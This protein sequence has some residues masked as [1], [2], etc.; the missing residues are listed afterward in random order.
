MISGS[1]RILFW[2]FSCLPLA[3]PLSAAGEAES[4]RETMA[5]IILEKDAE[6]QATQVRQ[7]PAS[8]PV[9]EMFKLWREGDLHIY[10]P[11][12]GPRRIVMV[13]A[14]PADREKRLLTDFASNTAV[15]DAGGTGVSV[16]EEDLAEAETDS[17]LR[18]AME[19]V[20]TLLKLSHS[21]PMVR[22]ESAREMGRSQEMEKLGLLRS[23]LEVENSGVV[24]KALREAIAITLLKSEVD[25]EV[26]AG[27]KTLGELESIPS[28]DALKEV[29]RDA[30][31]QEVAAAAAAALGAVQRH[32]NEVNAWGTLFRGISLGS[33]LLV[34]ALGLAI[35]F[36]LMGVIN[37]AHGEMIAIGAYTTYVVQSIFGSGLALSAFGL[38]VTLPGLSAT[39]GWFD[40]YFLLALPLSFLAAATVGMLLELGIIRF[41]YRRPLESLL[42]TWGVSLVLQQLFRLIIGAN[43]VSVVSP[44]WLSGNWT[45]NDVDL[46]WK[47]LFVVGFAILIVT[48][49][50]LL[51]RKTPLG[52]LIRAVMQNRGMAACMGVRT[53]RVNLL[54]FG[55]GSGLAGLAGA[56]LSQTGNVGPTM[57][58]LY[59]IDCFMTVVVGGVGNLMGTVISALGI[60]LADNVLQQVLGSPVLGKILVLAAIIG[61]LQWRPSGLFAVRS[62]SLEG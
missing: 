41:L 37:M 20:E 58:Q 30:R 50:G 51:L 53:E 22:A 27:C 59:I 9:V 34:A 33:I 5:R 15:L 54:T 28:Q 36:G 35:T 7:L 19:A 47:R 40:C 55:F 56:F 48:G 60:G 13:R 31:T 57:G 3:V 62:R 45:V 21:D 52:L 32:I 46:S 17:N 26:I 49:V 29:K 6:L 10:E 23:R 1:F 24:R 12:N 38:A 42:A 2:F 61:F 39:G 44:S 25:E 14:D 43:N 8:G 18:R 16:S 11:E 4:L